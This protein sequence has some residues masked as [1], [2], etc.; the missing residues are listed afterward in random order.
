M[1]IDADWL[2]TPHDVASLTARRQAVRFATPA[3]RG[4]T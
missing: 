3:P 4:E 1:L 2:T